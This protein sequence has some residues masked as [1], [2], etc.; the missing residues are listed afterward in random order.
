MKSVSDTL[1]IG[2]PAPHFI[3]TAANRD[4]EFTLDQYTAKGPV[5]LEFLRG[6][7]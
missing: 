2:D 7:W 4:G 3:L 1:K 5:L 6:T